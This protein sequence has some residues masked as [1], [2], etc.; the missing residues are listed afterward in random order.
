MSYAAFIYYAKK[1]GFNFEKH[2]QNSLTF[3][4]D[5]GKYYPCQIIHGKIGVE[6]GYLIVNNENFKILFG[7]NEDYTRDLKN[8]TKFKRPGH[9]E[10]CRLPE[11]LWG[12]IETEVCPGEIIN[13]QKSRLS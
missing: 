4:Y 2:G 10:H 13:C 5:G 7:D 9:I 6:C 11:S 12:N 8:S 3:N 1:Y